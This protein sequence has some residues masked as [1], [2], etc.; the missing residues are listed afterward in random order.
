M[1]NFCAIG[2]LATMVG[3]NKAGVISALEEKRK[4]KSEK[5]YQN[6]NK[7]IVAK[8]AVAGDKKVAKV[9]AELA[10]HGF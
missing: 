9:S 2:E 3:W 6:K 8:K 4:V 10:K 1:R 5:Y 7:K